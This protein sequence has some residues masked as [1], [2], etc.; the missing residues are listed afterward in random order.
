MTKPED[1]VH[2]LTGLHEALAKRL[3][4][5]PTGVVPGY[6]ARVGATFLPNGKARYVAA[7][8]LFLAKYG[9]D[10]GFTATTGNVTRVNFD[11]VWDDFGPPYVTTGASWHFTPPANAWYA[12]TVQLQLEIG[13]D[14]TGGSNVQLQ[15]WEDNGSTSV[16]AAQW[17]A[18]DFPAHAVNRW[19]KCRYF[20]FFSTTHA[21]SFRIS[22]GLGV[23][24]NIAGSSSGRKI[25]TIAIEKVT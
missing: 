2:A 17:D 1:V 19:I 23:D 21:I 15:I 8:G 10:T 25:N 4:D 20:D 7:G 18:N 13:A 6:N 12:F 24:L 3:D 14:P 11:Y 22:N 9:V 16:I 5:A